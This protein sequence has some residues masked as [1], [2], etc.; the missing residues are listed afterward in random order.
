[1]QLYANRRQALNLTAFSAAPASAG[2]GKHFAQ[3]T[4]DFQFRPGVASR[5]S[6]TLPLRRFLVPALRC[7]RAAFPSLDG[8]RRFFRR[9]RSAP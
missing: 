6:I 8:L 4:S 1:M 5:F 9:A 2:L 3:L 7:P